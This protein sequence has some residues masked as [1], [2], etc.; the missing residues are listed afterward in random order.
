MI[1][2]YYP[3]PFFPPVSLSEGCILM[4]K[5]CMGKYLDGMTKITNPEKLMN[6]CKDLE[7]AGGKGILISGGGD[8][9]GR[10]IGLKK[11]MG[12]LKKIREETNLVVAVHAG[13]ADR[14]TAEELAGACDITFVDIVGS[15]ETA[16]QVAG[17]DGRGYIETLNNLV[18]AGVTTTPHVTIGLHYGKIEGEYDALEV[19]KDFPIKKIVLNVILSTKGTDFENIEIPSTREIESIIKKAEG[20]G[21]EVA[22]GCMHPRKIREIERIAI[23]NGVRDIAMPSEQSLF[24]AEENGHSVE[25]IQTC[26]GLSNGL[27]KKILR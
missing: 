25:K 1:R 12:A 26:C 7:R 22:L 24:Y 11:S 27:I 20:V 18:S 8:R 23:D 19:L 4:C 21:A 14:E 13:Y 16:R 6:F 15:N 10:I 3:K 9:E 17:I 2:A 5:H